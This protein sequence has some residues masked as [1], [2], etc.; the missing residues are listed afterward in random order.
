MTSP[1]VIALL[2][3]RY[4]LNL[5]LNQ[6]MRRQYWDAC[7]Y[8]A[9]GMTTLSF[10][11]VPLGGIDAVSSAAKTFEQ[12]NVVTA[13]TLGN[14]YYVINQIRT[15]A[16]LLP[17]GRQHATIQ[18]DA[19]VIFTT[20]TNC[21]DKMLEMHRRGVLT[22]SRGFKEDLQIQ[23][24]FLRAPA[25]FGVDIDQHSSS[26]IAAASEWTK[27]ACWVQADNNSENVWNQTPPL[28]LEP[29]Q[30]FSTRI[31]WPDGAGPVF[32][33]LVDGVS[34]S[35]NLQVLFDGYLVQP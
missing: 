19:N 31:D 12:T 7:R 11:Q 4:G 6:V 22:L 21:M 15:L 28:I 17:F 32:T 3:A 2:Q 26:F 13:G 5:S 20:Y 35:V 16:Y 8:T 34:P 27:A 10:F 24:P 30:P 14:V 23:S 1:E 29:N 33:N 18:A 9:A 25:G